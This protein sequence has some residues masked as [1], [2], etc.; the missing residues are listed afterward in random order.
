[1]R[2]FY[3]D[4]LI[5]KKNLHLSTSMQSDSGNLLSV[6]KNSVHFLQDRLPEDAVL[7]VVIWWQG[8]SFFQPLNFGINTS[9]C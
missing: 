1:M 8:T 5:K 4:L 6:W 2:I 9:C 3:V 7:D